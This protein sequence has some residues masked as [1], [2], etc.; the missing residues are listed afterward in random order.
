MSAPLS[1]VRLLR[2]LE[3][4]KLTLW[5]LKSVSKSCCLSL[6]SL[7]SHQS[8]HMHDCTLRTDA[9]AALTYS[10]AEIILSSDAKRIA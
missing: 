1:S 4:A 5:R 3:V 9:G 6:T 2:T 10:L 7:C 8:C